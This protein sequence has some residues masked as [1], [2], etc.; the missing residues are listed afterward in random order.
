MLVLNLN[1][2]LAWPE[3]WTGV[4]DKNWVWHQTAFEPKLSDGVMSKGIPFRTNDRVRRPIEKR[5][6]AKRGRPICSKG[7]DR[8]DCGLPANQGYL[9]VYFQ[10]APIGGTFYGTTV[11]NRHPRL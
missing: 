10:I 3:N 2:V 1:V 6:E 9:V 5:N 8:Q 11:V 7:K 4:N